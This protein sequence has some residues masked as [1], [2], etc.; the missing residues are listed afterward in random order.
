MEFFDSKLFENLN[1]NLT[2]ETSYKYIS[3]TN[4]ATINNGIYYFLVF[5]YNHLL[6]IAEINSLII[7][8]KPDNNF[9]L[10]LQTDA[11]AQFYDE[12]LIIKKKSFEYNINN[13]Y[14]AIFLV[15]LQKCLIGDIFR[16]EI[17]R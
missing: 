14:N 3:G 15:G 8:G 13:Q 12:F 9:S 11:I 5:F 4:P 17:N 6:G 10:S 7:Y 1:I 16:Y 2:N